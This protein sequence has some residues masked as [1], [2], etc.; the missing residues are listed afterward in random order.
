VVKVINNCP[1]KV[2]V[3]S[4]YCYIIVSMKKIFSTSRSYVL[5]GVMSVAV[6]GIAVWDKAVAYVQ[7]G[8]SDSQ[9]IRVSEKAACDESAQD[10][11]TKFSGCNSIL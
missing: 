2:V 9:S 4:G 6:F 10:S 1:F 8:L 11:N 5:L 7:N 3:T